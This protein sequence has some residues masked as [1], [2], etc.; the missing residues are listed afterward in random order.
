M[1]CLAMINFWYDILVIF[2]PELHNKVEMY[3][4]KL[5]SCVDPRK[6]MVTVPSEGLFHSKMLD[7]LSF[8]ER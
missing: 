4:N 3:N 7:V 6:K 5:H 1:V 8:A 2:W